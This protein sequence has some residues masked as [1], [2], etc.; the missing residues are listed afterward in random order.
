MIIFYDDLAKSTNPIETAL[1]Q[2]RSFL[3]AAEPSLIRILVNTWNAQ[4]KAITYKELREAILYAQK[5]GGPDGCELVLKL[6]DEWR[7]DYSRLVVA[8]I[9]PRWENAINEAVS[10]ISRKYPKWSFNATTAGVDQWARDVGA[11]FV[12]NSTNAQIMGLRELVRRAASMQDMNVDTL[13]RVIRPMV[14][15][16]RQQASAN[17]R[18]YKN[19]LEHG[20]SQKQALDL[21]VRYGSIQ[22]RYRAQNIAR[23]ELAFSANQGAD[24]GVRQAQEQGYMG[25]VVKEWCTALDER[26]C[27]T[28]SSLDGV[29]VGMDEEFNFKTKLTYPGVR[30][31]PPCHPSCRCV[32]LYR[33]IEPPKFG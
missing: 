12:T 18:Y 32:V 19:L 16:T 13:S 33:E 17:M 26:V 11:Q 3:D 28:C 25:K 5:Y 8:K 6:Y 24:M 10:R 9:A 4:G 15:L 21:S 29:Q 22:H 27:T 1:K 20:V 23:T 2:L 30:R 7:Q 31:C 14:G